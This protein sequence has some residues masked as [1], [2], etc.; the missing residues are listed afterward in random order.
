VSPRA[1]SLLLLAPLLLF[2]AALPAQAGQS[3]AQSAA[4]SVAQ[5]VAAPGAQSIAQSITSSR[6]LGRA[7]LRELLDLDVAGAAA[8][9][10]N[11]SRDGLAPS[12]DRQIAA[13]RAVEL[14]HIGAGTELPKPD[15]SAL[16]EA[17]R[18]RLQHSLDQPTPQVFVDA[19]QKAS[20]GHSS[21]QEVATQTALPQLRPFVLPV[22]GPG[23]RRGPSRPVLRTDDTA[24]PRQPDRVYAMQVLR[25]VLE[26]RGI[27]AERTRRHWFPRFKAEP[28]PEDPKPA[29][30]HA[31]A[32]LEQWLSERDL[33]PEERDL[34][35]RLATELAA[36]ASADAKAATLLLDGLPYVV[37]RLR[38]DGPR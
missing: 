21:L 33:Q 36:A 32:N 37:E 30:A 29:L 9:Y 22:P 7:W 14:R 38:K 6:E 28:W 8:A 4:Q 2:G 15:L 26:H 20:A 23:E 17:M 12:G 1:C 24:A 11:I 19:L 10:G 5:S 25:Q 34:L 3:A 16:P 31:R 18:E 27:D 13:A 35:R